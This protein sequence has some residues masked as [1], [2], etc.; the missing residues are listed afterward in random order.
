M[1][2][3]HLTRPAEHLDHNLLIYNLLTF[4]FYSI[5]GLLFVSKRPTSNAYRYLNINAVVNN[6]FIFITNIFNFFV[7]IKDIINGDFS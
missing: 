6:A 2:T 4:R 3:D 5:D 1:T 7:N